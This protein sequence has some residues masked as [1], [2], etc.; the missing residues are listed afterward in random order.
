MVK[1]LS[2]RA[3]RKKII[4]A[5]DTMWSL[6]VRSRDGW[7]CQHPHCRRFLGHERGRL[8]AHHIFSRAKQTTRWDLI[9]GISLCGGCHK[10]KA[11]QYPDDFRDIIIDNEINGLTEKKY[12]ALR[13]SSDMLWSLSLPDLW[14]LHSNFRQAFKRDGNIKGSMERL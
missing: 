4:K 13:T 1:I 9:N 10:F 8:H 3:E 6:R 14:L 11:H 2:P 12:K 5:M 7:Q